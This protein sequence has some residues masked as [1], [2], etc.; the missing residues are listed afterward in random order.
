M[1]RREPPLTEAE[2]DAALREVIAKLPA[3]EGLELEGPAPAA[4][5][6]MSPSST[7][8]RTTTS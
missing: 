2:L 6:A 8:L 4:G 3:A 1:S 5:T 7:D